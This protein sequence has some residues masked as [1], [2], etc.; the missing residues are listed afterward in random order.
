MPGNPWQFHGPWAIVFTDG[1]MAVGSLLPIAEV[2]EVGREAAIAK[3]LC[4]DTNEGS[5]EPEHVTVVVRKGKRVQGRPDGLQWPPALGPM[6]PK[7][8]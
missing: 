3:V 1:Q 2:S 8:P 4:R 6:E 5:S 7:L